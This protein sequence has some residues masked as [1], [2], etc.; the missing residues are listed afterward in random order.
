M[1]LC[2]GK[3]L[4]FNK[5]INNYLLECSISGGQFNNRRVLIPRILFKP[6]EKQFSFKWLRRQF[7]VRVC[8]A[9]TIKKS[10]GQTFQKICIWLSEPCFRHGQL[11]LAVSKVGCPTKVKFAIKKMDSQLPN[12][13]SNVVFYEV[14]GH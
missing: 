10:Q 4:I 1:G 8:F 7:P 6:K 2:N 13:T 5:V 14:L 11:L 9:M 3:R 12:F